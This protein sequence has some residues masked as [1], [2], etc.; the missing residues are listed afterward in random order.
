LNL[1]RSLDQRSKHA[2]GL[3][4]EQ[5]VQAPRPRAGSA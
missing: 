1:R 3:P 4:A 5:P 2:S